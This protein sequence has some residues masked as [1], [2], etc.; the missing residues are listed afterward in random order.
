MQNFSEAY[1]VLQQ[2]A[3]T[4]RSKT[5]PDL[6]NLLTIVT[7]SVTAYKVCQSRIA[8]VEQAL[9]A[10]FSDVQ[11][12]VSE[13]SKATHVSSPTISNRGRNDLDIPF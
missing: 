2:H 9:N 12:P 4:L 1:A 10:A 3:Q 7:E 5:E 8:A 6:D 13:A 11:V